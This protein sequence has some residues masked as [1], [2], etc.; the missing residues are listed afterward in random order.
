M[1]PPPHPSDP[2]LNDG[3]GRDTGRTTRPT[4]EETPCVCLAGRDSE[5]E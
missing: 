4:V 2:T 1:T 5:K 3:D